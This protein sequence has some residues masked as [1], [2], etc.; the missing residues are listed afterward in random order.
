MRNETL[1]TRKRREMRNKK[2][3]VRIEMCEMGNETWKMRN[4]KWNVGNAKWEMKL[5]KAQW[6]RDIKV[7]FNNMLSNKGLQIFFCSQMYVRNEKDLGN[8]R[9]NGAIEYEMCKMWNELWEMR[10]EMW[11]IE[12]QDVKE[13]WA[14]WNRKWEI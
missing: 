8:E 4:G 13:K 14:F 9:W 11:E 12:K 10:S 7:A 5:K 1:G 6:M 3:I 2:W